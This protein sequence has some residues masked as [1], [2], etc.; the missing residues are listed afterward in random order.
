MKPRWAESIARGL[1]GLML[2]ASVAWA[3]AAP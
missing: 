2:L 3:L 1:L